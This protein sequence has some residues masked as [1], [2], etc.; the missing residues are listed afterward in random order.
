MTVSRFSSTPEESENT[1]AQDST[2]S[3][4]S[5]E[6]GV[7]DPSGRGGLPVQPAGPGN[8]RIGPWLKERL[9]PLPP[10]P[11]PDEFR[12]LL[13]PP[14]PLPS[15]EEAWELMVFGVRKLVKEAGEECLSWIQALDPSRLPDEK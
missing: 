7:P 11:S 10:I 2:E 14:P 1:A 5:G 9:P 15:R 13:P 3:A 6:D 12:E 4:G 8:D